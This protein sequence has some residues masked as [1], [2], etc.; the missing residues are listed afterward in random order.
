[1]TIHD[2]HPFADPDPDPARRLRGRLGGTVTLW[3]SG[4]G[5]DRAG[6]TVTSIVVALGE[7]ARV[8][9]LVDPDSDLSAAVVETGTAVVQLLGW[10]DRGLAE[11]FAGTAPAPGGAF[12]QAEFVDTDWGPRIEH[13]T[14]WAGVRLEQ[15]SEV[16]WSRLLTCTIEH[17]EVGEDR[18]PLGHRRG[19]WFRAG[20]Q[21]AGDA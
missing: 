7:P 14:T 5:A 12:R 15:T 3:T 20:G 1:M 16:G 17:L 11:A 4:A 18:E 19:R 13:A 6:L 9:G 2:T 21:P 8:L 10:P